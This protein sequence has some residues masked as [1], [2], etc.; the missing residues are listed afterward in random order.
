[1]VRTTIVLPDEEFDDLKQLAAQQERSI[2]WLLRQAFR[3]SR[4]HL[5]REEAY[6]QTFDR[7]WDEIGHSLRRAGVGPRH[8]DRLVTEVRAKRS[9][10]TGKARTR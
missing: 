9:E 7:V 8:V 5:E 2:S 6:S 3:I 4:P 1:M 10:L